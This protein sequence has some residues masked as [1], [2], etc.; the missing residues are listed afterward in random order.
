MTES[1]LRWL[2][3]V[4]FGLNLFLLG[5][6]VA[7][8]ATH[9]GHHSHHDFAMRERMGPWEAGGGPFAGGW[10]G[11]PGER[12]S[13][14][15]REIVQKALEPTRPSEADRQAAEDRG[16]QMRKLVAA[17]TF[18]AEAFKALQQQ[19]AAERAKRQAARQQAV[20]E[21]LG[22]LSPDG[23]KKLAEAPGLHLLM[24]GR[25]PPMEGRRM[26]FRPGMMH[27]PGGIPMDRGAAPLAAPPPP[28][29]PN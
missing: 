3:V 2:L 10:Q 4:S 5:I 16:E 19:G 25:P 28:P 21:A 12:L 17:D 18:D 8:V 24:G 15:D 11:G 7:R 20:V 29:R 9:V 14:A 23:R 26:M 27:P 1:R 13:D 22:K 6:M